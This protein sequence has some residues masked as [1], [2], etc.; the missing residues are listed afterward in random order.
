MAAKTKFEAIR[1]Q[2]I[3]SENN[4][5]NSSNSTGNKIAVEPQ[6]LSRWQASKVVGAVTDMLAIALS[7]TF[8]VYAL[9]VKMH[10][11]MPMESAQVQLLLRLSK[12][13]R[14]FKVKPFQ[15]CKLGRT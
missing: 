8:F 10:Q 14:I 11:N 6:V 1:T 7:C 9:A 13:V 15:D 4:S 5:L 12:L 2:A 3:E